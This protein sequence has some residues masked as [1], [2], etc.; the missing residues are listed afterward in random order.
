MTSEENSSIKISLRLDRQLVDAI[1]KVLGPGGDV[2]RYLHDLIVAHAIHAGLLDEADGNEFSL[3]ASV[4]AGVHATALNV[5]D[6]QG[7]GGDFTERAVRACE[8]EA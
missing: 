5:F 4:L 7:F 1:P 3:K 6:T 2:N 8:A